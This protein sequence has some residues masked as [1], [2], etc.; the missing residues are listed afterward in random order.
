MP[1]GQGCNPLAPS[2]TSPEATSHLRKLPS[3]GMALHTMETAAFYG[4]SHN[5]NS[6]CFLRLLLRD[7]RMG[8]SHSV[9]SICVPTFPSTDTRPLQQAL[10]LGCTIFPTLKVP[11][12]YKRLGRK[13]AAKRSTPTLTTSLLT[14]IQRKAV[15]KNRENLSHQTGSLETAGNQAAMLLHRGT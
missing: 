2:H 8:I 7:R 10:P 3:P 5:A 15:G 6:C 9:H 14:G 13:K 1:N 4:S 12:P 11:N